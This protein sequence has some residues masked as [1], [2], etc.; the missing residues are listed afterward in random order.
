MEIFGIGP[1]ELLFIVVILLI[2]FGP[3]DMQR[4]GYTLR[5]MAAANRHLRWLESCPKNLA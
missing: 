2:L 1:S 5:K 3:K 4:A